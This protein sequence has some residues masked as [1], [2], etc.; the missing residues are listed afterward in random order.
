MVRPNF[1]EVRTPDPPAVAPMLR[2]KLKVGD[3][4]ILRP[5]VRTA[6]RQLAPLK[7][8][9]GQNI[10]VTKYT[11][12]TNERNGMAFAQ[13]SVVIIIIII[14]I[15]RLLNKVDKRNHSII[16]KRQLRVQW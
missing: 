10:N 11:Y 15:S 8:I 13:S 4:V 9:R 12:N 6:R 14:I 5:L 1:G 7:R 16:E 3:G 2:Y